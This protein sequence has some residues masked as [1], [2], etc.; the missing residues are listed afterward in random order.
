MFFITV[1]FL[2]AQPNSFRND[3]LQLPG[4]SL[5]GD[6][7][8]LLNGVDS[9]QMKSGSSDSTLVRSPDSTFTTS[10]NTPKLFKMK[11][12][13]W[14]A[15][16]LSG[17]LPGAGQFYNHSYW[18]IPIIWGLVGFFVYEYVQEDR[19]FRQYRDLYSAS[20]QDPILGPAGYLPYETEREFYRSQ[21]N[22]Y[23]WYFMIVYFIN[24][25][26]AYVDAHLFDFEVKQESIR[27]GNLP[28]LTYRFKFHLNF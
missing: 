27:S 14:L 11:K 24:L 4:L 17:V 8:T 20:Q 19:L 18:K 6:A 3:I 15:V 28:D 22:E 23:V 25:V 13:P 12:Q 5:R 10:K 21:K 9:L 1:P 7:Q 16:L 26:D 2:F